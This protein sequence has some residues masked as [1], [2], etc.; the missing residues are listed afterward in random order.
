MENRTHPYER[1]ADELDGTAFSSITYVAETGSTNADA[2][3]RLG[4]EAHLGRS[5][6][7]EHQSRG[8]GR[9]GRTWISPPRT[10]LLV[11]TI[12]P[13][14][15]DALALWAVPFWAALA[16]RAALL[17]HGVA[18]VLHWPNDLLLDTGGKVAGILCESRITGDTAWVACG[19]G[20]NVHR[21]PGKADIQPPP[22]FCDDVAPVDR[23][24]LLLTIL[25]E[26][27]AT[28]AE[29]GYPARTAKR[30]EAVAG[31]RGARYRIVRDGETAAFEAI[32]LGL[33]DGGGLVVERDGKQETVALADARVLR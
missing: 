11:T 33:G 10:S 18:T 15:V 28:L 12:L 30:W 7:A 1:I 19:V 2:V 13:R 29:L 26:Y 32:A 27:D 21:H 25:R 24:R 20:I 22:A 4:S 31:I 14:A 3:Q 17:K 9:R 16:V 8:K 6:V 5:I 23:A